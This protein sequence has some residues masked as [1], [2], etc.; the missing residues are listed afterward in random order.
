MK[1]PIP[2]PRLLHSWDSATAFTYPYLNQNERKPI[3]I[4]LGVSLIISHP[5]Y[6]Q[7][8]TKRKPSVVLY[9]HIALLMTHTTN[10]YIAPAYLATME[11]SLL[12]HSRGYLRV[13]RCLYI[14]W[15]Q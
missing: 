10:V 7:H 6:Q 4:Y 8:D 14:S 13:K 9:T 11:L 5:F 1:L 15:T 12:A 2:K 3:Q